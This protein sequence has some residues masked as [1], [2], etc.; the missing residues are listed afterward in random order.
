MSIK[1]NSRSQSMLHHVFSFVTVYHI[2]LCFAWCLLGW[3]ACCRCLLMTLAL[4]LALALAPCP[5]LT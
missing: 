5:A 4:G 2:F 3:P 1:Q